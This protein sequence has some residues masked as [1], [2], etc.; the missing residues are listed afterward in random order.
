[1]RPIHHA[2]SV[3]IDRVGAALGHLPADLLTELDDA[4]RI[5]LDL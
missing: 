3:S 4:I 2:R 5:H 1:V